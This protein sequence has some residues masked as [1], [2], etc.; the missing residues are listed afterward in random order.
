MVAGN[1]ACRRPSSHHDSGVMRPTIWT[2][3][4]RTDRGKTAPDHQEKRAGDG[5]RVAPGVLPRL[6]DR[7]AEQQRPGQHAE[8]AEHGRQHQQQPVGTGR[9]SNG[10]LRKMTPKPRVIT[11]ATTAMPIRAVPRP[12]V[13][14][15]E[16][17]RA[18]IEV[19]QHGV[20][21]AVLEQRLGEAGD[22]DGHKRPQRAYQ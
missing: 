16:L 1:T 22:A 9:R 12:N 13:D 21:L 17:V 18:H 8:Q 20:T 19:L 5:L 11:A 4:G 7:G 14:D 2:G 3:A 15:H 10:D 6:H